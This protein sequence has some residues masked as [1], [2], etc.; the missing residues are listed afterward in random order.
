MV[1]RRDNKVD[2]FQ[3]Q[4]SALRHQLDKNGDEEQTDMNHNMPVLDDERYPPGETYRAQESPDEGDSGAY[5]F[6]SY[7]VQTGQTPYAD[8]DLSSPA[9]PEMPPMDG[10][11]SVVATETTW[12]GDLV[13]G[14]SIHVYGRVEGSLRATE[15]VW[16]AQGADVDATIDA[17]RVIVAGSLGGTVRAT[18]RFEALP[19]GRVTAGVFAPTYIVHEG[20]VINGELRMATAD[21]AADARADSPRS[22]AVIQRRAR[23]GA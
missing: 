9:V 14:N 23:P 10:Q 21:A 11:I 22:S 5:S 6:G 1:F 2:S 13:S 8:D 15:D 17:R 19:Q 3:R 18:E 12:N 7:P 16:I 20:A 4:M